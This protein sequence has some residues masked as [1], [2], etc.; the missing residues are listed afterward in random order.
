[1]PWAAADVEVA[2]QAAPAAEG[3]QG[4]P[5][6]GDGLVPLRGFRSAFRDVIRPAHGED[7]GEQ[8]DLFLVFAQPGAEGVAGVVPAASQSRSRL[9]VIPEAAALS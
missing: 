9:W 6:A 4:M 3:G 5:V 7:S 1:M 8:E 2:A